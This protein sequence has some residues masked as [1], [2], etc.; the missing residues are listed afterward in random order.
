VCV[1]GGGGGGNMFKGAI[2]VSPH[3]QGHVLWRE[4]C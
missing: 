4:T 2:C 3:V 1:C